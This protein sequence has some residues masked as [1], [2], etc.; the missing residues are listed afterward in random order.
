MSLCVLCPGQG[1]QSLNMFD[2]FRDD[3]LAEPVMQVAWEALPGAVRLGAV[4]S[5]T[6]QT[7]A[8]AQPALVFYAAVVGE[9]L[10]RAG[11]RPAMVAGY[12]VG[13][14]S[15]QAVAGRL[16][17]QQA[18]ELAVLRAQRMDEASPANHGLMAIKGIRTTELQ[19][20]TAPLGDFPIAIYNDEQHCVV[21]GSKS[22]LRDLGERLQQ[23][24]GAHVVHLCVKVPSHTPWLAQATATFAADLKDA[25]WQTSESLILSGLAGRV[26]TSA[27]DS[28]ECLSRQL[29]EPLQWGLALDMAVEQ[30]ATVFFE[31][32]PSNTL[33]RMVRERYPDLASRSLADFKTVQG[34]LDWLDKQGVS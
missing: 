21:G 6:Y 26:C 31:T 27:Q 24:H 14:L 16:G 34:A 22:A 17:L 4:D 11:V 9:V 20:L 19:P 2:R 33:I 8:V 3:P 1:S 7:N 15:A 32:G 10:Q 13:E 28:M 18:V 23:H 29:S 30:G 25:D 5:A 12:S